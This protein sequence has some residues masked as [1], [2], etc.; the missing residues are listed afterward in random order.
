MIVRIGKT[1][2]RGAE[3]VSRIVT[4][5][6]LPGQTVG[7]TFVRAGQRRVV[8]LTLGERPLSETG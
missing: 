4:D 8:T 5:E 1:P 7:V 3:D 2:V 6:L